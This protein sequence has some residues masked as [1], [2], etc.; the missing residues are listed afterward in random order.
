MY[1]HDMYV[2]KA[3]QLPSTIQR[4]PVCSKHVKMSVSYLKRNLYKPHGPL[5]KNAKV[6]SNPTQMFFRARDNA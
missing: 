3:A 2:Y 4:V 5:V 6:V 1:G